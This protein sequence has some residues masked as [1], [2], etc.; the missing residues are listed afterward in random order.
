MKL[1]LVRFSGP[2]SVDVLDVLVFHG[3]NV[4]SNGRDGGHNF[5]EFELVKDGRLSSCIKTFLKNKHERRGG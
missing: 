3:L 4:E 2:K 5:T 1:K